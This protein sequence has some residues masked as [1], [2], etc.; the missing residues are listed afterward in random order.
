MTITPIQTRYAGCLF[1]S[2]LEARWAVFFD[3][4]DIPWRYEHQGYD[5]GEAGTYLPDFL[6]YPDTP[7][8]MW[9]E[10]KGQFPSRE[11][12]LKAQ[13]LCVGTKLP[14]CVYFAELA[15]PAP[16]HLAGMTYA[17]F[18][19]HAEEW[20]WLDQHGWRRYPSGPADWELPL[21][22]TAFLFFP[23]SPSAT[24]PPRSN[25]WWWTECPWC[26]LVVMKLQGQVGWCP[27]F[28]DTLPDYAEPLWPRFGHATDR[29]QAAYAK[30]RSARF[31][32]GPR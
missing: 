25:L 26:G 13:A 8:A 30:A 1:R 3:E 6:L 2:R 32:R 5:L 12:L 9:F 20:M 21:S 27:R 11:E 10:V 29:L 4:L 14:T 19:N 23:D 15:L 18:N 7:T 24:R 17:E 28:G 22:P 31:E 16:A